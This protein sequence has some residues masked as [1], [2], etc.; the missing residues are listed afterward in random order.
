MRRIFRPPRARRRA[1]THHRYPRVN[2]G[3]KPPTTSAPFVPAPSTAGPTAGPTTPSTDKSPPQHVGAAVRPRFAPEP[4]LLHVGVRC[5]LVGAALGPR[6]RAGTG[7]P[8][9]WGVVAC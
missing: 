6:I 4:A 9:C 5:P 3:M 2:S 8:T 1:T 7:A